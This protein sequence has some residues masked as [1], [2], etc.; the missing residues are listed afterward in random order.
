M[1]GAGGVGASFEQAHT[2]VISATA[3]SLRIL[4]APSR[5]SLSGEIVRVSVCAAFR[6][7]QARSSLLR[8]S[9]PFKD[10]NVAAAALGM[11]AGPRI[12]TIAS[13][14]GDGMRG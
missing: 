4:R 6:S 7:R 14:L 3:T 12:T 9:K 10:F 11:I 8:E 5:R 1:T 13:R 2:A